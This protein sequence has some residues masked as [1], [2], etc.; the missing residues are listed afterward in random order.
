MG[1]LIR[2]IPY[3][4]GVKVKK[5]TYDMRE[6]PSL[7]II[8]K[9]LEEGATVKAFDP[10]AARTA[11]S[12]LGD[13]ITYAVSLE[14][15]LKDSDCAMLVTDWEEFDSMEPGTFKELMR[16]PFVI[17]ARPLEINSR[18]EYRDRFSEFVKYQAIGLK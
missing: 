18:G 14:D 2:P 3:S 13:S 5:N 15:C 7:K 11:K 12:V 4:D 6:S 9:L 1:Y 10:Y 16:I 17:D 8:N